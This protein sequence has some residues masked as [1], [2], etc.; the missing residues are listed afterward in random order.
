MGHLQAARSS[1]L[2]DE[3]DNL[4]EALGRS[5]EVMQVTVFRELAKIRRFIAGHPLTSEAPLKAWGRFASWQI[6]VAFKRNYSSIGSAVNVWSFG[7]E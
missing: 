4:T 1:N 2:V 7:A 5:E 6:L 3:I